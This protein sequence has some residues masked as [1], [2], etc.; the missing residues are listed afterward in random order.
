MDVAYYSEKVSFIVNRFTVIP[1][2]L[3]ETCSVI[4]HIKPHRIT[5]VN[6]AKYSCQ[7]GVRGMYEKM[8]VIGHQAI[9]VDFKLAFFFVIAQDI[10][11]FGIII[12]FFKHLLSVCSAN[13]N[14]INV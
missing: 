12:I 14:V 4:F 5:C 9:C 1:A 2:L 8:N 3:Q 10:Q 7:W 11:V 13:Y 6:A